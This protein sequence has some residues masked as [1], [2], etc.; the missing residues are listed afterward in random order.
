MKF[1]PHFA[2]E[3]TGLPCLLRGS[4]SYIFS[5]LLINMEYVKSV[6]G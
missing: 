1:F 2:V 3:K 6:Y 5:G 4:L